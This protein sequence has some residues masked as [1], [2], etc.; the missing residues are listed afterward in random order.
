[1]AHK[2]AFIKRYLEESEEVGSPKQPRL[3]GSGYDLRNRVETA[4]GAAQNEPV[5]DQLLSQEPIDFD[6][7]RRR[8][9]REATLDRLTPRGVASDYGIFLNDVQA[10]VKPILA[11]EVRK[12]NGVKFHLIADIWFHQNKDPNEIQE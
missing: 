6:I 2:K 9:R 12:Q 8:G 5:A 3:E 4:D 1:M 7:T 10:S 11:E